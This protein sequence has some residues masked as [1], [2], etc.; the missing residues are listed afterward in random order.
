VAA[1]DRLGAI[2]YTIS[3]IA[4]THGLDCIIMSLHAGHA[5]Q[6]LLS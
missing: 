6:E 3:R 2:K 4:R 1:T 5:L